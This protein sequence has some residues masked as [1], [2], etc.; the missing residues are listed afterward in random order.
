MGK[1]AARYAL[2]WVDFNEGFYGMVCILSKC[3]V[4]LSL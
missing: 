1:G 3:L 4:C 2:Q